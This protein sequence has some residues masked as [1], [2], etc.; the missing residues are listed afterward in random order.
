MVNLVR[1]VPKA[2]DSPPKGERRVIGKF[3]T[4]SVPAFFVKP[5]QGTKT[6]DK[7]KLRPKE[8]LR[9]VSKVN[10]RLVHVAKSQMLKTRGR[11]LEEYSTPP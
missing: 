6:K 5:R 10:L 2:K 1:G 11:T 8:I 4:E 7:Q 9:V 3:R